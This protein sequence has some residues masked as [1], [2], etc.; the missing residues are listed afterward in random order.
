MQDLNAGKVATREGLVAAKNG[1][2]GEMG[3]S[4]V[5]KWDGKFDR[6][7]RKKRLRDAD[8][9]AAAAEGHLGGA[10]AGGKGFADAIFRSRRR[11]RGWWFENQ[12]AAQQ[13]PLYGADQVLFLAGLG[14]HRFDT[15][16]ESVDQR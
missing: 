15:E 16:I 3:E 6:R 11:N 13:A 2:T 14:H 5:G 4:A 10:G 1:R 7:I 8:R 12:V 9:K